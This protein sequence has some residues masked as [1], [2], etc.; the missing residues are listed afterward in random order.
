MMRPASDP[1]TPEPADRV[2]PR[3]YRAMSPSGGPRDAAMRRWRFDGGVGWVRQGVKWLEQGKL[4]GER[5]QRTVGFPVD[6]DDTGESVCHSAHTSPS[7]FSWTSYNLTL[8]LTNSHQH[9]V[10]ILIE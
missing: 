7:H 5:I 4:G 2:S 1:G 6:V 8:S 10:D 9:L 3:V